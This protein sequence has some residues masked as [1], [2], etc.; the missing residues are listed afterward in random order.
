MGF[1]VSLAFQYPVATAGILSVMGLL[2]LRE[3]LPL[4]PSRNR[5]PT[6]SAVGPDFE[7]EVKARNA[8]E[9]RVLDSMAPGVSPAQ[10]RGALLFYR[11]FR[12]NPEAFAV[13]GVCVVTGGT[14]FVGQR[15]VEMLVERG[16]RK[17]ISFDIVPK[18]AGAWEH[19]AI[20]YMLGDITDVAS[21]ERAV[22]GADCVWH[23]AAAVGPFHPL[24]L[25]DKVNNIGTQNIVNACRKFGV[26]KIVMSSSPSTRF[27]GSDIDG[28][29]EAE[30]PSIPMKSYL[31][32]YASSKAA[33]EKYLTDA[34]CDELMTVAV[35]PHQVYGPRDNLFTPNVM[36][37][38]GT[39]MLR[40]FC[41]KRTGYGRNRVCFTHVDNYAHGLIISAN[42][43]YVVVRR[44]G[45][46][47]QTVWV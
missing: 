26:P 25:Y 39:G 36:E 2:A 44:N 46:C 42:A 29:S 1:L 3:I 22:R 9:Q 34:C 7:T 45:R 30:M 28:L 12:S 24:A 20:E 40:V 15:L 33:G 14:G 6:I 47:S 11:K 13:P 18:P 38:A 43:L 31:Q 23:N 41:S 21:V 19:P 4:L 8:E 10:Q 16:A 17:V 32:A 37:A 5:P 27:D 35:A